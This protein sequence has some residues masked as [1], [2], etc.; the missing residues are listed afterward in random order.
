M[1]AIFTDFVAQGHWQRQVR[2]TILLQ[3][4]SHSIDVLSCT[5]NVRQAR[6]LSFF[7]R[8]R[9][10]AGDCHLLMSVCIQH[11]GDF[12]SSTDRIAPVWKGTRRLMP[13]RTEEELGS[14]RYS[15]RCFS[16]YQKFISE[17]WRYCGSM[18][19]FLSSSGKVS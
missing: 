4:V 11:T 1:K 10:R 3:S 18:K 13:S 6:L 7:G 12:Y 8:Y 14:S 2:C 15:P 5:L 19:S 9:T 17:I 16:W